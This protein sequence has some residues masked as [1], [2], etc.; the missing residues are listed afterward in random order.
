VKISS[1]R[2]KELFDRIDNSFVGDE[3]SAYSY[4]RKYAN[5]FKPNE[6]VVD[7][8]CGEGSFLQALSEKRVRGIGIDSNSIKIK[9]CQSK[10]YEAFDTDG[11]EYISS[12]DEG[13]DGI[14][15]AHMIEHLDGENAV[16]FLVLCYNALKVGGKLIVIT[17]NFEVEDVRKR[18]FWLSSTHIRP[19]PQQWLENAFKEIG[20]EVIA[21]GE[22]RDTTLKDTFIVGVKK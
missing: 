12:F 5:Y 2:I 15:N 17:P 20:F 16:R 10:G 19:Y 7:I 3:S 9:H 8:G 13:L 22:D 18:N 11:F 1:D 6:V 4:Q 14:F 21:S